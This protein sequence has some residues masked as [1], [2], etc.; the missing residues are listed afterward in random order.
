MG[1]T[2][3][4]ETLDIIGIIY[5]GIGIA[6]ALFEAFVKKVHSRVLDYIQWSYILVLAN[7]TL[8]GTFSNYL[9]VGSSLITLNSQALSEFYCPMGT[10][11][12]VRAF[13]LSFL[14][15]LVGFLVIMRII[16]IPDKVT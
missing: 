13:A 10:Y 15:V 12:C 9:Y 4:S 3:S 1:L 11:V 2:L 14:A 8:K 6:L 16:T 5:S 7:T